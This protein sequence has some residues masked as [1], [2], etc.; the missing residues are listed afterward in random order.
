MNNDRVVVRLHGA[1]GIGKA[2]EGEIIRI[3]TRANKRIVNALKKAVAIGY[4]T[5]NPTVGVEFSAYAKDNS[6]KLHF[7]AQ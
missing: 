2:R 3:I 7:S 1:A 6:K 5:K 4:I